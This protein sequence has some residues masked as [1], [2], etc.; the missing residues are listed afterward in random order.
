M[1]DNV[2]E[3]QAPEIL[4]RV[5]E[6]LQA[7]RQKLQAEQE[8]TDMRIREL[9]VQLAN[10]RDARR[11]ADELAE[12]YRRW[13]QKLYVQTH[14]PSEADIEEWRNINLADYTPVTPEEFLAF[15]DELRQ[16]P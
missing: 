7:L 16:Q 10:E 12:S 11:Q 14:P 2:I 1:G 6:E 8:R 9:E 13:G 3:T 15:L 4:A 5:S